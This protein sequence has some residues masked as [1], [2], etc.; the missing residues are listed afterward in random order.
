MST[1]LVVD[2][3]SWPPVGPG[4]APPGEVEVV[5]GGGGALLPGLHDHH[6]HLL[7]MAAR[8]AGS[9]STRL[10]DAATVDAALTGARRVRR[11]GPGRRVRR[12]PA[13]ADR[14]GP[15]RRPGGRRAVRVQH[16]SGLG[17][18]LSTG[19]CAGWA[20]STRGR[21]APSARRRGA[22]RR[23]AAHGLAAPPR[24]VAG[25]AGPERGAGP[26]RR[27]PVAGAASGS[28]ASPTRPSRWARSGSA[29]L[30]AARRSGALPQ[31]LVLLGI[32]DGDTAA[33]AGWAGP[34]AGQAAGRRALGLDPA[35]LADA[36]AAHHAGGRPVAIH[37]VTRAEN[38]AAVAALVQAGALPG[39]RIEHGSVLPTD[40]DPAL[41]AG[42]ITV[43]VQPPL[44]AERGDH[45]LARGRRRRPPVPAPPRLAAG[46]RRAGRGRQRRPGHR[47]RSVGRRSSPPR[48]AAPGP[49]PPSG[50]TR[51]C[52]PPP[53]SA[54]TSADPA[55]PRRPAP[56]RRAR[57][58]PPT[59]ASSTRRS[60]T[61]SPPRRPSGCGRRGWRAAGAP[62][63]PRRPHADRGALARGRRPRRRGGRRPGRAPAGGRL[64]R[65]STTSR[66]GRGRAPDD[67]APGD[68]RGARRGGRR[69]RRPRRRP[70]SGSTCCC[71]PGPARC[72]ARWVACPEGVEAGLDAARPPPRWRRRGRPSPWPSSSGWGSRSAAADA[73]VAESWVYSLLQGER[74]P[75]Q[76]AGGPRRPRPTAPPER[77]VVL[78]DRHDDALTLTL[79]R[80]EVR[81]AYGT[82][83]RDELVGG[84]AGGGGRPLRRHRRAAGQR[85]RVLQRR[86]PR[87]V[88]HGRRPGR[89]HLVRTD[90]QRRPHAARRLADRVHAF[91]HGP[92]V[93]AGVELPAFAGRVVARPDTT[94]PPARGRHGPGA[95]RRRHRQ[96]PPPHRPPPRR[97]ARPVRRPID[98]ALAL[99]WGLVDAIDDA[100]FPSPRGPRDRAP[101]RPAGGS[102]DWATWRRRV[103]LGEYDERW[104]RMAA[105]G[106]NPHGEADLVSRYRPTSVLDAGC[107]TGRVAIELARRGSTSSAPTSTPTCSP[108]PGPRLPSSPGWGRPG[109]PRPGA[110]LRR[111][112][113]GRERGR[114]RRP[115]RPEPGR[116]SA[117][118]HVAPGGRLISGFQQRAGWPTPDEYDAWC[119]AVGLV[120]EDRFA[121]W[122]GRPSAPPP[123]TP[124]RS[125]AVPPGVRAPGPVWGGPGGPGA[126]HPAS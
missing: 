93:G 94:L 105:A 39:D 51:P 2:G 28:P 107:G 79:D 13:R 114:L 109:R 68:A 41:A 37:A 123:T 42:G 64:G 119:A 91:V 101:D 125:T 122:D 55:R 117:A 66:R 20:C 83:M 38:V 17:W 112:R 46:G 58:R 31:R 19:R 73:V 86:R 82:R 65:R 63:T 95:R 10:P 115:R 29:L 116:G 88:R 6:V 12:A 71:A 11:V 53:P 120:R 26:R 40:L 87:R 14:P 22:R 50:P 3:A 90:P 118:A 121:T 9:T 27:R 1:C 76:L 4:L 52:R 108:G 75:P 106:E 77:P 84:P 124:C 15:A 102:A 69:R 74:P 72:R 126:Y 5:D 85:P 36:V 8:A 103:D 96:H 24:R 44:V 67:A 48:P 16:R 61:C 45:H 32:D 92:C 49:A 78:V 43:V 60:P 89:A 47:R 54:G 100:A 97:P 70:A 111:R 104:A 33:V 62:M 18:V 81:N 21:L 35:G 110:H 23:R 113:P 57:R 7:A 80:P 59:S 34:G 99:D 25:R 56:P 30:G 98:A